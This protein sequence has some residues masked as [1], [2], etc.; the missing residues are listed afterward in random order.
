MLSIEEYK[1][2][3]EKYGDNYTDE[4]V[5]KIRDVLHQIAQL[6]YQRLATYN[7]KKKN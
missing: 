7:M 6:D 5:K 2:T 3:L 4:E 1:Y